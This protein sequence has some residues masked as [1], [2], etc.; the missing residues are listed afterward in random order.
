MLN[1]APMVLRSSLP[2]FFACVC[3]ALL[4][5]PGGVAHA[6]TTKVDIETTP[7]GATVF[8]VT[9]E[10]EEEEVGETPLKAHRV[11]R[12]RLTLRF[13]LEG[14]EGLVETVE[15]GK[16]SARFVFKLAPISQPG[17]LLVDGHATFHGALVTLD[18]QVAGTLPGKFS[19]SAGRHQ[20]RVDKEGFEPFERWLEIA[21]GKELKV[22]VTLSPKT[23]RRSSIMVTSLPAGADVHIKGVFKGKT[24]L[25]ITDLDAAQHT[26][27]VSLS[28]Y[29]TYTAEVRTQE[30]QQAL[31]EARLEA[32][33]SATGSIK[34]L[35]NVEGAQVRL[36]G[37]L[38]GAAPVSREGLTPGLHLVEAKALGHLMARREVTVRAGETTVARLDLVKKEAEA[39]KPASLR[40]VCAIPG[41]RASLNGGPE[42][43]LDA[44]LMVPTAGTHFVSVSAPDHAKW[45][46]QFTTE[47]GQELE[48]V[49]ELKAL[50]KL[51]VEVHS[52]SEAEVFL[53]DKLLGMTPLEHPLA[54]G[55]HT[56][57]LR[58]GDDERETHRLTITLGEATALSA[59]KATSVHSGARSMPYSAKALGAGRGSLGL[60]LGWPYIGELRITGGITDDI[61]VGFTFRSI[62]DAMSEFEGRVKYTFARSS[63][64]GAALEVSIG[65]GGGSLD[66]DSFI[67]RSLFLG[68]LFIGESVA[69]SI[70]AGGFVYSDRLGPEGTTADPTLTPAIPDDGRDTALELTT[71]LSLEFAVSKNWNIYVLF[72]A[73]PIRTGTYQ[74][75]G[76]GG[77]AQEL[78]GRLLLYEGIAGDL[79]A[80]IFR[81]AIG[82]SLLF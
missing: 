60:S 48:L 9:P 45:T 10:G 17:L 2:R 14:H 4:L 16:T 75:T 31:L 6:K 65:G 81:G 58:R 5:W 67:F 22:D 55:E 29:G 38:V 79:K 28:G 24:P 36:D 47:P 78:Q 71:G 30:G 37:E 34:V 32:A 35:T 20:L 73:N 39:P 54:V 21:N 43:G 7:P 11:P 80:Q 82:A 59:F 57:E 26:L 13:A 72:E 66:R 53:G 50:G 56:L 64:F 25:T 23:V 68:S 69:M 44:P 18:G 3:L 12:G 76:E 63:L 61:D 1:H 8:M 19:L 62:F 52:G 42:Q 27:V 40:I 74:I 70:R 41:A 46:K 49:A 51:L 33:Q 77:E 15:V